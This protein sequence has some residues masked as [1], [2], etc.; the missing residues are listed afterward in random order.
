LHRDTSPEQK[1]LLEQ[2][3]HECGAINAPSTVHSSDDG[4]TGAFDC[5]ME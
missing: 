5:T 2:R 1:K 3:S 4:S